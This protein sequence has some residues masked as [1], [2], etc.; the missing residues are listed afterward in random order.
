MKSQ[1][2]QA[3]VELLLC[4]PLFIFFIASILH[5]GKTALIHLE[6]ADLCRSA[7]I[8]KSRTGTVGGNSDLV[9]TASIRRLAEESNILN[10]HQ[11]RVYSKALGSNMLGEDTLTSKILVPVSKHFLG[12]TVLLSYT[13][14]PSG[15]EL[16]HLR[17]N[18]PARNPMVQN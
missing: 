2:G 10:P 11:I 3:L 1:K 4:L 17:D 5:L 16:I 15:G 18:S 12:E 6:A 14:R 7:A 9:L 8:L 13:Y